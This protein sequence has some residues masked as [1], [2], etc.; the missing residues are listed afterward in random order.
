MAGHRAVCPRAA[1]RHEARP[2]VCLWGG[3]RPTD[4]RMDA[5]QGLPAGA[6]REPF[7]VSPVRVAAGTIGVQ[8]A[9]QQAASKSEVMTQAF[10]EEIAKCDVVCSNCHRVR[11]CLRAEPNR[12]QKS[13]NERLR[14]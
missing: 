10:Y 4:A 2:G 1:R 11:T 8:R 6:T 12:S 7:E 5:G 3:A 9:A 13:E 14:A